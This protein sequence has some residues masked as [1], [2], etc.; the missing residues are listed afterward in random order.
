MAKFVSFSLPLSLAAIAAALAVPAAAQDSGV[1]YA[2]GGVGEG[3]NGY[4]GAV[5]ALPGNSLGDGLAIRAGGS[6]GLY[7]YDSNGTEIEADYVSGELAIVYQTSGEWGWANF[8]VGPRVT[9]TWT[10]PFDPGNDREGT[11]LDAGVTTDG[12]IGNKWRVNWF[13]SLGVA[14]QSYIGELRFGPLVDAPSQSRVGVEVSAQGD[15]SYS[16]RSY[17]LFTSTQFAPGWEGRLSGGFSDQAARDPKPYAAI[18]LSR[19]F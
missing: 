6:G 11:R 7:R 10:K 5:V 2:G 18:A 16:R 13:G 9:A 15:D 4:V 19:V 8:G 12:A 17:G 14:D 3:R 1:V